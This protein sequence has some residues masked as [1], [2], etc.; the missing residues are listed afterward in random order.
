MTPLKLT[1]IAGFFCL[2]NFSAS[3]D[4]KDDIWKVSK[5]KSKL[6][7]EE[8]TL[9]RKLKI[10]DE[11]LD[12]LQVKAFEAAQAFVK[13]RKEHPSLKEASKASDE[14]KSRM[15]KAKM[16]KDKEGSK[17]ALADYIETRK[18]LENIS[19]SIPELTE[20]QNKAIEANKA[21]AVKKTALLAATPEGKEFLGE[22][23]ALDAKI[24]ELRKQ[25]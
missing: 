4:I 20:L 5:E 16:A 1:L 25:L 6:V 21:V 22:I 14:A 12:A 13:A 2:F 15:L 8:S 17:V 19:S 7:R 18:A 11:A 9:F 23:E 3:A 10:K 24:A